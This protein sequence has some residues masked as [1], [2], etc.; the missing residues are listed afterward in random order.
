LKKV[1][2][3]EENREVVPVGMQILFVL[4][5]EHELLEVLKSDIYGHRGKYVLIIASV[6]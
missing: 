3:M 4:N 6:T 5:M 1:N 2:A